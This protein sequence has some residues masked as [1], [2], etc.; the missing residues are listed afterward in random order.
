MPTVYK[1]LP[2]KQTFFSGSGTMLSGGKLYTY[3]AGT[4]T[5]KDTYTE[6]DGATTNA[7][8][9]ILNARGEVPN[10]VFGTTG[11]Y[12][13]VL[14]D[15]ADAVIWTRDN[16]YG[17]GDPAN[18]DATAVTSEWIASGYTPTRTGNTTFTTPG[19]STGVFKVGRR[20]KCADA[21][22]I[23]ATVTAASY[24]A[25]DVL[26]TV[27]VKT[28]S[29]SLS[30]ALNRVDVHVLSDRL[31]VPAGIVESYAVAGLPGAS[32]AGQVVFVSDESGGAVLAFS[33]G[34]N[35]RRV[36][37]RAIVS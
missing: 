30:S 9:I 2:E 22:T 21:S 18:V 8:P 13:L 20:L 29:G 14:A 28:D 15:S 16:V 19:D 23:Y 4:S 5:P 35:W 12:K 7:N 27:T 37:D 36:T 10:G 26:T 3:A 31:S 34:T 6:I 11:A 24:S 33:D 32:P 25:I 17:E 1:L